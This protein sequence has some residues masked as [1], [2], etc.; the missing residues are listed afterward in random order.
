MQILASQIWLCEFIGVNVHTL[1][2][3]EVCKKGFVRMIGSSISNLL[4]EAWRTIVTCVVCLQL[5][6]YTVFSRAFALFV[7]SCP[8]L[9]SR[10]SSFGVIGSVCVE[11]MF[12]PFPWRRSIFGIKCCCK[13]AKRRNHQH[14][15]G[16]HE[17]HFA[18]NSVLSNEWEHAEISAGVLSH[19]SCTPP[20][21]IFPSNTY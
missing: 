4:T 17:Y 2:G 9:H 11:L 19:L 21:H 5:Q 10:N 3:E 14:S 7:P 20:K 12:S 6:K 13:I 1:K 16:W 18:P 15:V 8:L